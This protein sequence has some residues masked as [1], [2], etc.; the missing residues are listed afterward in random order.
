MRK[1][2]TRDTLFFLLIFLALTLVFPAKS[3]DY[4][5]ISG[6]LE[7]DLEIDNPTSLQFGPDGKL[8]VARQDGYIKVY[9]IEK[10][11]QGEFNVTNIETINVVRNIPN[12][13]D[14]GEPNPSVTARQVTGI[15]L[16]GTAENPIMY[17]GSSDPRM[18]AGDLGDV[19]LC[20]NSGVISKLYKEGGEWKKL[21]LVRGLPRS[22]ENHSVNGMQLDETNNQLL[23]TVGGFTNSGGIARLF[24][25]SNEYALSACI[26]SLD[27]GMIESMEVKDAGGLNPYI[28]DMPTLDDPEREN[29]A[30][31]NDINDP[32]GGNDGLN[33][34]KIVEGGPVQLYAT[35]LRN[36][37]DLVVTQSGKI[38]TI[39]NGP[40]QG[41]GGIP[42]YDN[43]GNAIN[44]YDPDEPGSTHNPSLGVPAVNNY[45]GFHY[46]GDVNSYNPGSYYGGHP[47]PI[48]ANPTGAGWFTHPHTDDIDDLSNAHWRTSTDGAHPLPSDWPP[49]PPSMAN[50][51]ESEYYQPGEGES[52]AL[53]T[54]NSASV[55]GMC[56]YT[57]SNFDFELQGNILAAN[58]N[59]GHIHMI[60]LSEDGTDVLNAK[61]NIRIDEDD[62]LIT[63]YTEDKLLD[64]TSQGDMDAF[65]GTIWAVGYASNKIFFFE[66]A[67]LSN[68]T[69]EYDPALDEDGDCYMNDDEIDNQ[70]NPCNA[71]SRPSDFNG[72]C[73]SDLNDPDD[74]SDG[75]LDINDA[76]ARDAT[77][78]DSTHIPVERPMYN[79]NPGTGFFGLGFTGLM[80]NDQADYLD[81]MDSD[82][83]IAGG[84]AGAFTIREVQAG[85]AL[86]G[87]NDQKDAFQFGL[88]V[89]H[90]TPMFTVQA[91]MIG[92]YFSNSPSG[93][94]SQGMYV[95][96]GDQ[97]NY[98][99]VAI[100][101][102]EGD[103]VMEVVVENNGEYERHTYDIDI[104]NNVL[105]VY[106]TA[107]PAEGTIQASYAIDDEEEHMLG[108]P[109]KVE[110]ALLESLQGEEKA[111]AVGVI[112][113]SD[114]AEPFGATWTSMRIYEGEAIT[115]TEEAVAN[116]YNITTYPNPF[117]N[118]FKVKGDKDIMSNV[119]FILIDQ[120]GKLVQNAQVH[121]LNNS[122]YEFNAETLPKGMYY[123]KIITEL[124]DII[125]TV[126]IQKQ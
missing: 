100:A 94:Q 104:T 75:I 35:G 28:Y 22:E 76:F 2:F 77:N 79:N 31:G 34:A 14:D 11:G 118:T 112:A 124:G 87:Q 15:L 108:G 69:A 105:R 24:A 63:G 73:V 61:G 66:P 92:P 51:V 125:E 121:T 42:M 89:N 43:S 19:H 78:G 39:D 83:Y 9:T 12:H 55:N 6:E 68:C 57:A 90:G 119:R 102:N 49:I 115:S 99:K 80:K 26:I 27:L 81:Q 37:Y 120:T 111:L 59:H 21:D 109:I 48:R 53:L 84:A 74:D 40:N 18:G 23:V 45:D 103:P 96:N 52:P 33:Q 25:Y 64:V 110:G 106:L 8:Y 1:I 32:W 4:N 50:P 36:P 86:G 62:P 58:F 7:G 44:D 113:T 82:R 29:D 70:T 13:D 101:A 5:F 72:N 56:E 85:T 123:L 30:D 116:H 97:D 98:F 3:Q 54:W 65:P 114:G 17:V 107:N 117:N 47:C 71:A 38:Y 122:E 41:W 46:I 95:G 88:N 126:K 10:S 20:T 91:N 16:T 93:N 60:R 67:E